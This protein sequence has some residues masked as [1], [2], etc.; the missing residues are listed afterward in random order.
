M[1]VGR[2]IDRGAQRATAAPVTALEIRTD[3]VDL[4]MLS[5]MIGT[6]FSAAL[7]EVARRRG[8]GSMPLASGD[9]HFTEMLAEPAAAISKAYGQLGRTMSA[10]HA[11]AIRSYVAH[12]P[13][14]K[15]GRHEYTA[16]DWGFDATALREQ[17]AGY[18]SAFGVAA[19][20][21]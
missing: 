14:G 21:E 4:E 7:G 6:V 16:A 1:L 3:R 18:M 19:E 12:K 20:R 11:A 13:Q 5:A 2:A 8:D 10:E 15:F 9:V 17:L